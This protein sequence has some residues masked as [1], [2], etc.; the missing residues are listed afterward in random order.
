[1]ANIT[2]QERIE[3]LEL[4]SDEINTASVLEQEC[5]REYDELRRERDLAFAA[6]TA[7][8]RRVGDSKKRLDS[9]RLKLRLKRISH[10]SFCFCENKSCSGRSSRPLVPVEVPFISTPMSPVTPMTPPRGTKRAFNE[11]EGPE[12]ERSEAEGPCVK[13]IKISDQDCEYFESDVFKNRLAELT[14]LRKPENN[15]AMEHM[16]ADLLAPSCKSS[17]LTYLISRQ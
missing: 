10:S 13:K 6:Y 16:Y 5:S 14:D 2:P 11:E 8:C 7:A 9:S 3:M 17:Y 12:A 4:L 1:M 15:Q